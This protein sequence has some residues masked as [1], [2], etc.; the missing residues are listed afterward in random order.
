[1]D[2]AGNSIR[3]AKVSVKQVTASGQYRTVDQVQ[4]DPT[5]R[6][7]TKPLKPGVYDIFESGIRLNRIVHDFEFGVVCP[8]TPTKLS[9]APAS[10]ISGY[11]TSEDINDYVLCVQV[12][13]DDLDI[14][15]GGH[16][17]PVFKADA[18]SMSYMRSLP[19]V[20]VRYRLDQ[21]NDSTVTTSFFDVEYHYPMDGS[22]TYRD[23][24]WRKVRGVSYGESA[25]I[26]V[27]LTYWDLDIDPQLPS[28]FSNWTTGYPTVPGDL[29]LLADK[30]N[31]D[32]VALYTKL[33][34]GTV[35]VGDVVLFQN[36]TDGDDFWCIIHKVTSSISGMTMFM[37]PYL[38]HN[39]TVPAGMTTYDNLFVFPGFNVTIENS[40]DSIPDRFTVFPGVRS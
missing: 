37:T 40:R 31:P 6:F 19:E 18:T 13:A 7:T 33:V 3:A 17:Y 5:G 9:K 39:D 14:S 20:G 1:M 29:T 35:G 38:K 24:H 16:Q 10:A 22:R 32:Q 28:H 2:G 36:T 4:T 34:D 15:N 8:F 26:V 21:I 30:S 11:A 27:P 25:P 23:L 12:E